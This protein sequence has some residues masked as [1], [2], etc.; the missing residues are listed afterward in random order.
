[1]D[2]DTLAWPKD[3]IDDAAIGAAVGAIKSG[4]YMLGEQ[5]AKLPARGIYKFMQENKDMKL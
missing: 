1:M 5:V 3:A 4:K 2:Y